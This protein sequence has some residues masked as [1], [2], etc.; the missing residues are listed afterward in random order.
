[1]ADGMSWVYQYDGSFAGLLCCVAQSEADGALPAAI[2]TAAGAQQTFFPLRPVPTDR[3]VARQVLGRFSRAGARFIQKA[4]LT[5][6]PEKEMPLCRVIRKAGAQGGA[7]LTD[8]RD[9][10]VCRLTDAVRHLDNEAHLLTGFIR[11]E[12]YQGVLVAVIAPKNRV[13]PLLVRHFTER[14]NTESFLIFDQTHQA[15]L[16][17]HHSRWK[18]L[19]ATAITLPEK[20]A[21]EKTFQA[22]WKVFH[23]AVA[24][25]ERA[26]PRCQQ[27]H[28]PKRY[29]PYMVE[30][31]GAERAPAGL[32]PPS[33]QQKLSDN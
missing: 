5:A 31:A 18:I 8:L 22:M 24:I 23:A 32:T 21:K 13:L 30:M 9:P 29:R 1:M 14:Y 6:L 25:G 7:V 12:D 15:L 16:I 10:D 20:D 11:F 28:L 2:T 33:P 4:F 19:S 26:N 27:T 3:A 17:H